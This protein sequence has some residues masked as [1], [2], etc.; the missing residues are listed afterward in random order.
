MNV[1]L[2]EL[3]DL[4][5]GGTVRLRPYKKCKGAFLCSLKLRG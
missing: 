2:I 5:Y 4:K 3:F 1:S